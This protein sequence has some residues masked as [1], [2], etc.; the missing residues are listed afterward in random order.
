MKRREFMTLIGIAA[1]WPAVSRAQ[2]GSVLSV[3]LRR[4]RQD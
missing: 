1:A 4:F 3:F 2:E